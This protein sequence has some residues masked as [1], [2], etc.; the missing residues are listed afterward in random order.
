MLL[1]QC[2]NRTEETKLVAFFDQQI[3][4]F[5]NDPSSTDRVTF[6]PGKNPEQSGM[7]RLRLNRLIHVTTP[8]EAG[9]LYMLKCET[10]NRPFYY[11]PDMNQLTGLR[12]FTEAEL[13]EYKA[14][15]E[16]ERAAQTPVTTQQTDTIKETTQAFVDTSVP[17]DQDAF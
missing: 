12:K 2:S 15:K 4:M 17:N 6:V 16:A 5:I 9:E 8:L 7:Y 3:A 10:D 13:A 1:T 14:K 11:R